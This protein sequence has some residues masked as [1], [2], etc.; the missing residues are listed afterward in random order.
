[1]WKKSLT[2]WIQQNKWNYLLFFAF[3][4]GLINDSIVTTLKT[5]VYTIVG[6]KYLSMIIF[7]YSYLIIKP[8]NL[9][10]ELSIYKNNYKE[11]FFELLR[12]IVLICG[13]VFNHFEIRKNGV[14]IMN[15]LYYTIPFFDMLF[16]K[17]FFQES[18]KHKIFI[19]SS[20]ITLYIFIKFLPTNYFLGFT[21]IL[22]FSFNNILMKRSKIFHSCLYLLPSFFFCGYFCNFHEVSFNCYWII[23]GINSILIEIIFFFSYSNM[24]LKN[25]SKII[26]LYFIFMMI[27][28]KENM[29]Y[30]FLS[31]LYFF[32]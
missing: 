9:N 13:F 22:L 4:L 1:M 15:F 12:S 10:Q 8:K 16:G 23:F 28:N 2:I 24:S 29:M 32:I 17:I 19:K 20:L 3:L 11:I 5:D 18:L 6:I 31:C 30:I 7:R 26:Y 25:T 14:T 27:W 21:S